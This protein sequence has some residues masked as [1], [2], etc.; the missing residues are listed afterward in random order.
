MINI[1]QS[2]GGVRK[3]VFFLSKGLEILIL[4][5]KKLLLDPETGAEVRV[6]MWYQQLENKQRKKISVYCKLLYKKHLG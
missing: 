3:R 5:M 2:N 4:V 6:C 1:K